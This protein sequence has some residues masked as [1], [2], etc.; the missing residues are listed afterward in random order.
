MLFNRLIHFMPACCL[1]FMGL[2]AFSAP[3]VPAPTADSPRFALCDSYCALVDQNGKLVKHRLFDEIA[4]FSTP[5]ASFQHRG[6]VGVIDAAGNTVLKAV[7]E[8][9]KITADGRY[10][11]ADSTPTSHQGPHERPLVSV[12]TSTGRKLFEHRGR[13]HAWKG[14]LFYRSCPQGSSSLG[15]DDNTCGA[16]FVDDQG[17]P[18]VRFK[19]FYPENNG[20]PA[21]ASLDGTHYGVLSRQL[22][23]TGATTYTGMRSLGGEIVEVW[24]GGLHGVID[25][26]GKVIVPLGRYS[27][28]FYHHDDLFITVYKQGSNCA[29]YLKTDGSIVN[30]PAGACADTI[31][32]TAK[33][34]YA[35]ISNGKGVGAINAQGQ[36]IVPMKYAGLGR[37]NA[38]FIAFGVRQNGKQRV[39]VINRHGKVMLKAHYKD[40][41]AG[42]GNTLALQTSSGW[43]LATT[44][45][46]WLAKPHFVKTQLISPNLIAMKVA[47]SD[48][49]ASHYAFYDSNGRPLDLTSLSSPM[50]V[51]PYNSH[52][53]QAWKI[54]P[55][56]TT[57]VIDARGKRLVAPTKGAMDF[58]YLGHNLWGVNTE[59]SNIPNVTQVYGAGGKLIKAF[60]T[61]QNI[62]SFRHGVTTARTRNGDAVLINTTGNIVASFDALYP[63]YGTATDGRDP[64][65]EQTLNR[66][67]RTDPTIVP[68]HIDPATRRIC[69][70]TRLEML[71]RATELTYYTAQAGDCLPANIEKLRPAYDKTLAA[72]TT[73][74]CM[75]RAMHAFQ[76]RIAGATK[77]CPSGADWRSGDVDGRTRRAVTTFLNK[78]DVDFVQNTQFA[79]DNNVSLRFEKVLLGTHSGVLIQGYS[80]AVNGSFWLVMNEPH[81]GWR[82]I[83]TGS[84]SGVPESVD[85]RHNGLPILKIAGRGSCCGYD[86]TYYDYD[87][88]RYRKRNSCN[89]VFDTTG[90]Q[91]TPIALCDKPKALR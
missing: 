22:T 34:G 89:V 29:H 7:Y 75:T 40:A 70:N 12:F 17:R 80:R 82:L 77:A 61:L 25:T 38:H 67:L 5:L 33:V 39:G 84:G 48:K 30:L 19:Q 54:F 83:L 37:I 85:G 46:K 91:D 47:G 11:I 65:V 15:S 51:A 56:N 14:H 32:A 1:L 66:C 69:A 90:K 55:A 58:I 13:V 24:R 16:V 2:P 21:H 9:V 76:V 8:S 41:K 45:G 35:L 20:T 3:V 6:K 63:R 52:G 26:H 4:S 18:R 79:H 50:Q 62:H 72:C 71:S 64:L 59:A 68:T 42:P 78:T 28:F 49:R 31:S 27:D 43:G 87:G 53:L 57:A 36:V 10:L 81:Q 23:F 44:S 60:S 86:I 73:G 74:T 88:S